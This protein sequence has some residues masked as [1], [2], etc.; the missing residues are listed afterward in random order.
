M[1]LSPLKPWQLVPWP[2]TLIKKLVFF[3]TWGKTVLNS[4]LSLYTTTLIGYIW[5]MNELLHIFK[6]KHS[7]QTGHKTSSVTFYQRGRA[8]RWWRPGRSMKRCWCPRTDTRG[9]SSPIRCFQTSGRS[10]WR[11]IWHWIPLEGEEG[12]NVT[13]NGQLLQRNYRHSFYFP[14]Q[15][16]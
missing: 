15:H 11:R 2:K 6:E 4:A 14:T 5:I 1:F 3:Q 12:R 16:P 7:F 10:S 8:P 13:V 9:R